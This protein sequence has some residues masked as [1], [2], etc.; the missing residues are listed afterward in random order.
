MTKRDIVLKISE[1]TGIKQIVVKEVVHQVF[2]VIFDALKAG[3]KIEIRNFGIF[4]VKRRKKRIGR[5]P[6]TGD[7]I[8]VPERNTVTFKPGLEIKKEI[9]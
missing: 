2:N 3:K 4:K 5:N 9:K 8:P 1:K 6:K 7:V